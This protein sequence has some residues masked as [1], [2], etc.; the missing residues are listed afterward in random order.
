[1]TSIATA[2]TRPVFGKLPQAAA[3]LLFLAAAVYLL[4]PRG[5]EPGGE[6]WG[7]WAAARILAET[8]GFPVFSRNILYT[9]WLL[10]FLQLPFPFSQDLEYCLT[11]IFAL[12]CLFAFLRVNLETWKAACLVVALTPHLALVEGGGTVAALGFFCLYLK[13][14]LGARADAWPLV[15]A[16]LLAAALCH[17]AFW[18]FLLLH[19]A[20][21]LGAFALARRSRQTAVLNFGSKREKI[22]LALLAGFTLLALTMQ[23]TRFDHNHMLMDPRFVP[24]PLDSAINI[25]FFQFGTWELVE[26]TYDPSV[27][28]T[29]DWFAETPKFFGDAKHFLQVLANDPDLFTSIVFRHAGSLLM[30]PLYLFSFLPVLGRP[31]AGTIVLSV[32]I[33]LMVCIGFRNLCRARGAGAAIVM[34]GGTGGICTAFLLTTFSG[35]YVITLV[36]VF[37][38]GYTCFLRGQAANAAPRFAGLKLPVGTLI[39]VLGCA[40][41]FSNAPWFAGNSKIE[42]ACGQWTDAR[43]WKEKAAQ[44]VCRGRTRAGSQLEKVAR[45]EGFLRTDGGMSALAAYPALNE[46]AK[47]DARILSAEDTFFAAFTRIDIDRNVQVYTLPPY[48]DETAYTRNILGDIDI[49]F[50]SE[51]MQSTAPALST[52]RH[53]RYDLHIRPYLESRQ[54]EFEVISIPR[55]GQVYVRKSRRPPGSGF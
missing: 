54:K 39:L 40:F 44:L 35:R 9:A 15:P 25:A 28:I 31:R 19:A 48:P 55:Y 7:A 24:V 41:T 14:I 38:L 20:V 29:K 1:M 18:P 21:A 36:P 50:I 32:L 16:S 6:S 11:H 22:W 17:S 3:I 13:I 23:S 47:P 12:A 2:D 27:W 51:N 37:L 49:F 8:H 42:T 4:T 34:L 33:L 26:R 10:P 52:Q 46:L 43:D 5:W 45:G 53:I 30:L